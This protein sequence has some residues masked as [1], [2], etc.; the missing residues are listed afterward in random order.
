MTLAL[1]VAA[2]AYFTAGVA[3]GRLLARRELH[4]VARWRI[5]L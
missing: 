1:I 2:V 3:L 5:G 4:R